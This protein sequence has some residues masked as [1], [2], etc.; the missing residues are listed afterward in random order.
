MPRVSDSWRLQ[1]VEESAKKDTA[2]TANRR[3]GKMW[4]TENMPTRNA[5]RELQSSVMPQTTNT[6]K[7]NQ[8]QPTADDSAFTAAPCSA[9]AHLAARASICVDLYKAGR[10]TRP[11]CFRAEVDQ[12]C[13]INTGPIEFEANTDHEWMLE[14]SEVYRQRMQN[15]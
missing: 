5:R 3:G 2:R 15:K 13:G 12:M 7:P 8:D 10:I 9:P 6:M 14:N 1:R 11:E 4:H